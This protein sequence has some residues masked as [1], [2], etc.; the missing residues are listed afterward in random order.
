MPT[1]LFAYIW[2]I[3]DLSTHFVSK[4]FNEPEDIIL[5]TVK[6]FQEFLIKKS[7]YY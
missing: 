1:P 6:W 2:D 5:H 3:Y 4:I 7:I